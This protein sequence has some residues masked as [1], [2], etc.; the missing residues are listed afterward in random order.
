ML[1][2]MGWGGSCQ[3]LLSALMQ[4]TIIL[5]LK[6]GQTHK[7][8]GLREFPFTMCVEPVWDLYSKRSQVETDVVILRRFDL[9]VL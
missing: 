7:P 6:D 5:D 2:P 3:S 1:E 8:C 4:P 9:R